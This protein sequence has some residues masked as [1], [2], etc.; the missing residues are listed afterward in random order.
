MHAGVN[1]V[2]CR[3]KRVKKCTTNDDGNFVGKKNHKNSYKNIG[4]G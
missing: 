3:Y 4:I 1:G 2:S